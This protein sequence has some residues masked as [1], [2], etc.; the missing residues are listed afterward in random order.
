MTRNLT[1]E[2]IQ[3]EMLRKLQREK[4]VLI[5]QKEALIVLV[6]ALCTILGLVLV[7]F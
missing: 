7:N 3:R 5:I 1:R 6:V 2:M 4:R